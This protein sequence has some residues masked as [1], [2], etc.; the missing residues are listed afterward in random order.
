MLSVIGGY[1]FIFIARVMDVTLATTRTLM[2]VR[3]HGFKAATIGFFEVIIYITALNRVVSSLDNPFKL[4]AYALGFA[5]GNIAGSWVEG[6]LAI[7][8]ATAQVITRCPDLAEVLRKEGYGVTVIEGKGKDGRR[9]ML[10]ISLPRK[11]LSRL[12]DIV[13]D[14]DE[15]A[16]IMIMDTKSSK[17]GYYRQTMQ[18]K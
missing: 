8:L 15:A 17:G 7:G 3:G 14:K 18:S 13:E 6:K 16:F 10:I 11:E 2:L 1:L 9:D 4:I 5:T 12:M